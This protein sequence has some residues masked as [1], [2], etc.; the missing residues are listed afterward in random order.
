MPVTRPGTN[1]EAH[2]AQHRRALALL[3]VAERHVLEADRPFP[4]LEVARIRLVTNLR[5]EVEHLEEAAAAGRG[6]RHRVD[7]KRDLAHRHLE[8]GHEGEE[9]RQLSDG[10]LLRNH[11]LAADPQHQTH[12]DEVREGHRRGA[13]HEYADAPVGDGAGTRGDGV[14]PRQLEGLGDEGAHHPN[15]A[16]VLLHHPGEHRELLLQRVPQDTEPQ[17]GDRGT[18][19]HQW[20]EAEREAPEQPVDGH[21]QPRPAADQDQE[22]DRALEPRAHPQLGAFDVEDAPGHQV[23]GVHPVVVAEREGLHLGVEVEAHLVGDELSYRLPLVVLHH[24]AESPKEGDGEDEPRGTGQRGAGRGV[25]A[26]RRE[27]SV[28]MVD[29]LADELRDDELRA[30]GEQGGAHAYCDSPRMGE[31]HA[32]DAQQHSGIES[33]RGAPRA[34]RVGHE[35][36]RMVGSGG[37]GGCGHGGDQD[38]RAF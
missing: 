37:S 17:P 19:R 30:R 32:R 11:L 28:R 31:G 9:G 35:S 25:V 38:G 7:R 15:A 10:E 1:L 33:D 8:D 4:H 21:E 2:V 3:A 20:R 34:H 23:A 26:R 18:D 5:L 29:C 22:Q 14:E 36:E 27:Q 24:R 13:L 12:R 16:E 6:P